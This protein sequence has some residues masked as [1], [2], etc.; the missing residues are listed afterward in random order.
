MD[1]VVFENNYEEP[2]E[3]FD[4]CC[5]VFGQAL[6]GGFFRLYYDMM[7]EIPQIIVPKDKEK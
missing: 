6:E 4:Y 2:M 5:A 7:K 3:D 1:N